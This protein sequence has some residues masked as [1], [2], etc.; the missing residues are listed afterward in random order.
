VQ[1]DDGEANTVHGDAVA[2][3]HVGQVEHAG[4][5]DEPQPLVARRGSGDFSD[6]GDD[7]GEHIQFA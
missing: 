4:V 2:Q 5:D 1:G 7:A 6:R 3:R